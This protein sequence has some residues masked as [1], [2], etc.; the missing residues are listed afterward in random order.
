MKKYYLELMYRSF[1]GSLSEKEEFELAQA[2]EECPELKQEKTL[3]QNWRESV[4]KSGETTFGPFF[5]ARIISRISSLGETGKKGVAFSIYIEKWFKVAAA[6]GFALI[7]ICGVFSY[8][9]SQSLSE[10]YSFNRRP[11]YEDIIW[12]T[13]AEQI[14][15]DNS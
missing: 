11:A 3:I 5:S 6:I 15:E 12:S 10:A 14:V 4:A 2:F 13:P 8:S 1:G 9:Q 7:I